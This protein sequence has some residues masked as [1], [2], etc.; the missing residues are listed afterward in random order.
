MPTSPNFDELRKLFLWTTAYT[1]ST[2]SV[3]ASIRACS[4]SGVLGNDVCLVR[5]VDLLN[6][7]NVYST[8]VPKPGSR[9]MTECADSK[10]A[11]RVSTEVEFEKRGYGG[12][13]EAVIV[14]DEDGGV[15]YPANFGILW[16]AAEHDVRHDLG[17]RAS[18]DKIL[19]VKVGEWWGEGMRKKLVVAGNGALF[20]APTDDKHVLAIE[21]EAASNGGIGVAVRVESYLGNPGSSASAECRISEE[22]TLEILVIGEPLYASVLVPHDLPIA[23]DAHAEASSSVGI[24]D[25][26]IKKQF[27]VVTLSI[28]RVFS[29]PKSM[30]VVGDVVSDVAHVDEDR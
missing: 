24:R 19:E 23:A 1:T 7:V 5:I 26:G 21:D 22:P 25:N 12:G 30:R 13:G 27:S 28:A 3:Q 2:D 18:D 10:L 29:K 8:P 9:E 15:I 17:E 14:V 20:E 16:A 4:V 11:F 6:V